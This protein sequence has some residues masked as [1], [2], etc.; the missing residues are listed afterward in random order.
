VTYDPGRVDI[1]AIES[2]I[3]APGFTIVEASS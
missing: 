3:A 2:A 1:S